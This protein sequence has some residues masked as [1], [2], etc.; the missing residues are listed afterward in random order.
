M[1]GELIFKN[2]IAKDSG[3][4]MN[5]SKNLLAVMVYGKLSRFGLFCNLRVGNKLFWG[6]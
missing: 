4:M 1:K 6:N 2:L 3:I 5:G